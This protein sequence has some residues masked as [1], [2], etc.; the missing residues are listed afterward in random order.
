MRIFLTTVPEE[1]HVLQ[2]V[3]A[4][5]VRELGWQPYQRDPHGLPGFKRVAACAR[6]MAGVDAVLAIVG[7]RG[8]EVPNAGD[9]GDG[10]RPWAWWETQAALK[11]G[12]PVAALLA[13]DSWQPELREEGPTE[14]SVMRDFRGD[15]E[16][17]ALFFDDDESFRILVRQQLDAY[18]ARQSFMNRP[19]ITLRR[20]APPA[21][22][23][24]PYPVLLPYRHP[25]LFGGRER[26][27][28]D[29]SQ[30]LDGSVPII[31]LHAPSGTGKSSFLGAGLV[32]ELRANGRPVAFDRHPA[33]P[34]L[35]QR[36]LSDLVE[37]VSETTDADY[38]TF[39]ERLSEVLF[40]AKRSPVLVLDQFEDLLRG[41][42]FRKARHHVG[43][44]LAASIQR[45]PGL[46]GAPCRWIL[47]YR[48]E[49]HGEV[50][51]WLGQ[52]QS[53]AVLPH[54]LSGPD[55]FRAWAFPAFG[56]PPPGT[57][58]G[59]SGRDDRTEAA[60]ALF[61][62]AIEKPLEYFPYRFAGDGTE[63][64]ALAF[65]E[66]RI[67][68]RRAPLT[69]ELQVVLA[70]LLE[71]A[72]ADGTVH[73]PED[74]AGLIDRALEGHL[75][76]SLDAAFPMGR[77]GAV[78]RTRALLALRELADAQGQ[79][80]QGRSGD[81]L[82][83]AIGRDGHHVLEQLATPQTRIVLLQP[84]D[85]T[86]VYV[87]SHDR[88][89]EV[90]VRLVDDESAY[91]EAPVDVELLRL[92]RF[93]A[94]QK[95]LLNEGEFDQATLVT[96]EQFRTIEK[97]ADALLWDEKSR[98]WWTACRGRYHRDRERRRRQGAVAFL[99]VLLLIAGVWAWAQQVARH[100]ALLTTVAEGEPAAAFAAL[101]D[102]TEQ[103]AQGDKLRQQLRQREKPFDVVESGLVGVTAENRGEAL[104]RVIEV[105][106]PLQQEVAPRTSFW[107][108]S[109]VWALDFF[110]DGG[111]RSMELRN[112]ILAPLRQSRPPP[113]LE[114]F[115]W[116][117]I[118]DGTFLMGT[119]P[120]DGRDDKRF[121][122]E[123]PQHEVRISAFRLLAHEVT[124]EQFLLSLSEGDPR[125]GLPSQLP[126]VHVNWY[127]AYTY[128]AWLGGR[129]PTEAEMEYAMRGGCAFD[130][131]FEDGQEA[132]RSDVAWWIANSADTNG[133]PSSRPVMGRA[134]TP[135]G[136][137][138]LYGNVWEWTA[139]WFA[140]YPGASQV[141]SQTAP[142]V[143]PSG[144]PFS[145][146]LSRALRGGSSWEMSVWMHPS[147]RG[148]GLPDIKIRG[149][150]FRV[151][152][153]GSSAS[154]W[155]AAPP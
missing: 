137:Y 18:A 132:T 96:K 20:W 142:R 77:Q 65:A 111:Q 8:G 129:L 79:R 26:E 1:L 14:P 63:R 102:L 25:D 116:A 4:D 144:P 57:R 11:R 121:A 22:P 27:L 23:P 31:G 62:A 5:L 41:E 122:D 40:V 80:A 110:A 49:F 98:R 90:I 91:G 47:S 6:Q 127:D 82:A 30:V 72:D 39:V 99:A 101:A 131:C 97:H 133:D 141:P 54:D 52:V 87:L 153:P 75:R 103:G 148:V 147:T 48:Q 104:L 85:E 61:R 108:A 115:R 36:L 19:A 78:Q 74:P 10:S 119:G 55:R 146:R 88:M 93:V 107:I 13:A 12:L 2:N 138:D 123:K 71:N 50:F 32:A 130:Y 92:R 60:A 152:L 140:P 135:W 3:A 145:Q 56:A 43:M 64:L 109:M 37:G 7:H 154:H 106:L 120:E 117:D 45:R 29:L 112:A 35:A 86:Q 69:P 73:V 51:R 34:G 149:Y 21:R 81:A 150:G 128:A 58:S 24:M 151:A 100:R 59:T 95:E 118:P 68:Q 125:V 17:L 76:R 53:A 38:K 28:A 113:P 134:A 114:R 42:T 67:A 83:R 70:D 94:L 89:A 16:R 33:E 84:Q 44:L 9:G 155:A 143:D 126:A 136:L 46:A 66:A 124:N 15:L 139:D 105:L